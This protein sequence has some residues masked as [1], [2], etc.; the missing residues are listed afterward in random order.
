MISRITIPK[1]PF[2]G[3]NTKLIGRVSRKMLFKGASSGP[4]EFQ[5]RSTE[6]T[7]DGYLGKTASSA[8]EISGPIEFYKQTAEREKTAGFDFN[9]NP[10]LKNGFLQGLGAL[11]AAA[12][13]TGAAKGF[14][15]MMNS[16]NAHKY[17]SALRTAI[18]MSPTLQRHGYDVLSGYMPMIIKA[19]PTVAEEPRLLA[20]YLESMLD[21]E[22]H[23]NMATMGELLALEGQVLK[24]RGNTPSFGRQMADNVTRSGFDAV[25]REAFRGGK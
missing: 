16:M 10:A 23:L 13:A 6:D 4:I 7:R 14:D 17:D 12:L 20:N 22:G 8:Q 18:Q 1:N 21:A 25:A 15:Y 11:G 3:F 24:N 5:Q 2:P 19:S 9:V